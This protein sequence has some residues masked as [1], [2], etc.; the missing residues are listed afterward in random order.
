MN[1][2]SGKRLRRARRVSTIRSV[3]A[4]PA[5]GGTFSSSC[6]TSAL[7]SQYGRCAERAKPTHG[8]QATRVRMLQTRAGKDFAGCLEGAQVIEDVLLIGGAQTPEPLNHCVGFGSAGHSVCI[9]Q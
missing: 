4:F 5:S 6:R 2:S 9:E 7:G 3:V 1:G 8:V